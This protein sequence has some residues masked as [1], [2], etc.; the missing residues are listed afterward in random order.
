MNTVF[1]IGAGGFVGQ[2]LVRHLAA[3]GLR[4]I[5]TARPGSSATSSKGIEWIAADLSAGDTSNWPA[6]YDALIYL[7]QSAKWRDFPTGAEDVVRVNLDSVLRAAEHARTA[8][9]TRFLHM[10]TGSVYAQTREP[11]QESENIPVDANRSF[12]VASK[13]AAEL[14]LGPYSAY[15]GLTHLRLFMPYGLGE[16]EKMLIPRLL[17]KI[18]AGE[19]ID[20][21]G[22]DGLL[23]NPIYVEDV[24][25]AT[26]RCLALPGTQTLNLGGPDVLTLRQVAETIGSAI[27]KTPVFQMKPETAPVI[28]GDISR[29]ETALDWQPPTRFADGVKLWLG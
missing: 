2:H 11:A 22:S 19:A 27:G 25:E 6:R 14:M 3:N 23:S 24:A 12:Y 18:R 13:L 5:A 26:R 15:Y 29:L 10:S 16:N 9:A 17:S 1:V 21:H 20:L 4:V 8:G 28:V 7:A